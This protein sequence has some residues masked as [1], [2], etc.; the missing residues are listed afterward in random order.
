MRTGREASKATPERTNGGG[1]R[2][3][4]LVEESP[5]A[6]ILRADHAQPA[7]AADVVWGNAL[8]DPTGPP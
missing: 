5:R 4:R 6:V 1:S 2:F 8:L 3:Q 7:H